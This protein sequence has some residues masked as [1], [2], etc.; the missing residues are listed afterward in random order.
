MT[1]EIVINRADISD[2]EEILKLQKTA[3]LQEAEI[4][5]VKSANFAIPDLFFPVIERE[6]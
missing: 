1:T 3:Y 4:Y 5:N 2:L 6:M